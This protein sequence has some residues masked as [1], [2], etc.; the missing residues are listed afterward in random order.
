MNDIQYFIVVVINEVIH[1]SV[2]N[3]HY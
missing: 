2:K 3:C 1:Q